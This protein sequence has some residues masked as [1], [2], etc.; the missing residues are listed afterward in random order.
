MA[1]LIDRRIAEHY[2]IMPTTY[3]AHDLLHAERRYAN[4]YTDEVQALFEARM[5][6]LDTPDLR[7]L[8]LHLYARPLLRRRSLLSS[9][10][11]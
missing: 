2:R 9:D 1:A 7:S 5:A 8:F 3:L 4:R 11:Q 10:A 6:T